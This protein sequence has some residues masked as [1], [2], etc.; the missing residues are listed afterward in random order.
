MH[1]ISIKKK[2]LLQSG[3]LYL[4]I[5]LHSPLQ[6]PQLLSQQI[7]NSPPK[8]RATVCYVPMQ[9]CMCACICRSACITDPDYLV[10]L[11]CVQHNPTVVLHSPN[12]G[13]AR[14]WSNQIQQPKGKTIK[15]KLSYGIKPMLHLVWYPVFISCYIL[16]PSLEE[17]EKYL[18][19]WADG[20]T[21]SH[22]HSSGLNHTLA[23]RTKPSLLKPEL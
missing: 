23:S 16:P 20:I 19:H 2:K 22:R 14:D 10:W 4:F 9:N 11:H 8:F 5:W 17:G 6:R 1:P 15:L 3:L 12:L 21:Y 7:T 18:L 13:S